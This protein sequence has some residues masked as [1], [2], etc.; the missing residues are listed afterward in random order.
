MHEQTT[1]KWNIGVGLIVMAGFMIYGFYLIY[2]RDFAPGKE[3]WIAGY[4]VHPHFEARLA[5]V[6]GNLFAFL[7]IVFGYLIMTLP[8]GKSPAK[9]ASALALAGLL[10]PLGILSE[11]YLGLPP[12][13]VLLGA[14]SIVA[15]TVTLGVA[16]ILMK[17]SPPQIDEIKGA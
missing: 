11:I 13:L 17:K 14:G 16:V 8:I 1:G 6:H 10:M 12:I 3:A 5:H 15:A 9:W 2:A 7:N 4:A